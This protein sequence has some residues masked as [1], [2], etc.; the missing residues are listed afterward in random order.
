MSARRKFGS[1]TSCSGAQ[2]SR[3]HSRATA[4]RT[5][6]LV[7]GRTGFP[8]CVFSKTLRNRGLAAA[9]GADMVPARFAVATHILL[10]LAA[11]RCEHA[12]A[13][14]GGSATSFWLA[15]RVHTNP[16]VVRR[17]SCRSWP[18]LGCCACAAVPAAQLCAPGGFDHAG[19]RVARGQPSRRPPTAVAARARRPGQS[20]GPHAGG[21]HPRPSAR[22]KRPSA[23]GCAALPC[24][25]WRSA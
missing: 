22:P 11:A 6:R 13:A 18:A 24:T 2:P 3:P 17:I 4:R 20:R 10:L 5:A 15:S 21:A 19:G 14:A 7:R 16:V 25:I 12:P 9:L 23:A 8:P 1:V